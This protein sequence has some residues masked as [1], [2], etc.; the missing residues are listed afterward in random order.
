MLQNTFLRRAVPKAPS[1]AVV[2]KGREETLHKPKVL[3][4]LSNS[5][6]VVAIKLKYLGFCKRKK[7]THP[8]NQIM[9]ASFW[10]RAQPP[11]FL[12][13]RF[14]QY[15]LHQKVSVTS[16]SYKF[17]LTY[18][19]FFLPVGQPKVWLPWYPVISIGH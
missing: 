17:I 5:N 2:G 19:L 15:Q 4:C 10:S 1:T 6:I 3:G 18:C 8:S 7:T 13:G 12:V 9:S 11:D 16:N 14:S